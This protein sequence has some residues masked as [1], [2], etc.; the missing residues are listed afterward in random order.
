M[1]NPELD[2]EIMN[3]LENATGVYQQVIDLMMIA[4]RKNR[5]EAAKDIDDIVNG[6]LARLILQADAKGM[7]LYAI[8]KDKQVIGGCLLAYRKGEESER[9]VN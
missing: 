8:D 3:T 1:S 2:E 4:I 5:P 9:W 7:E 6:G